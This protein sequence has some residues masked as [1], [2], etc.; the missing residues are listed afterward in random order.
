M[1]PERTYPQ[2][3]E[4]HMSMPEGDAARALLQDIAAAALRGA[5]AER[6]SQVLDAI[7]SVEYFTVLVKK[8]LEAGLKK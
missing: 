6:T 1:E 7:I 5:Q 3:T 8:A 2:P 4:I